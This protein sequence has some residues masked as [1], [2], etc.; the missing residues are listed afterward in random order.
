M[1]CIIGIEHEGDVYI[2]VDSMSS[3]G[4]NSDVILHKK[5]F[6]VGPFLIGY[7]T[8]FRMGQILE[9]SLLV[10]EQTTEESDYHYM[11]VA[12]VEAVRTALKEF[13][14]TTIDNNN[15]TGGD[16][17]VGYK[18]AIYAIESDFQV[19]RSARGIKTCGA[20]ESYAL[21]AMMALQDLPIKKR[22]REALTIAS[23]LSVFVTKPFYIEKLG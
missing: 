17:I 2:A 16:F 6:R 1:T 3:N 9:H 11:V 7:T 4:H 8:S 18:D 14:F 21:A 23:E 19:N 12:F 5:V 10:R 22:L 20:G 15:E 13:G